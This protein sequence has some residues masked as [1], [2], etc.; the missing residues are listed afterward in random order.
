MFS[1]LHVQ[2]IFFGRK[3]DKFGGKMTKFDGKS[4]EEKKISSAEL[5]E[6]AFRNYVHRLSPP[7][8]PTKKKYT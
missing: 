8:C 5:I 3:L 1:N 6:I 4:E 2:R 7:P